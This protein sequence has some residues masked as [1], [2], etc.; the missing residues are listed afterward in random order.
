MKD[1]SDKL[2]RRVNWIFYIKLLPTGLS[3][4]AGQRLGVF[5]IGERSFY[6]KELRQIFATCFF[7]LT[8]IV[9]SLLSFPKPIKKIK[10]NEKK[11]KIFFD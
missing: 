9:N 11:Q 6:I 2:L 8:F 4:L 1:S 7:C 10:S 3:S 5:V